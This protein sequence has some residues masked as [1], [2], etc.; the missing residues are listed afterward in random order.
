MRNTGVPLLVVD[1]GGTKCL[2]MF[3]GSDRSVLGEGR[4]DGCNYQTVG[5][6]GARES[7]RQAITQALGQ[8]E[9]ITGDD[10]ETIKVECAVFGMAGLDTE[11]DHEVLTRIIRDV[12]KSE[13]IEANKVIVENDALI[14]LFG[15]AGGQPSVLVISGTGSIVCGVN[16]LG[17]YVRSGGWGHVAGD[18]GSGY[19]I[20]KKA[21]ASVF[22]M[23]DGRG[24]TTL[25]RDGILTFLGLEN[26]EDL[27]N[28]IYGEA[29]SV[30]KVADLSAIVK[31]CVDEG[32]AVAMSIVE[33]S[34]HELFSGVMAVLKEL[35]MA[36]DP[37]QLFLQG[38]VL[39]HVP[40][41]QTKLMGLLDT[42]V[43]GMYQVAADTAL[44]PINGIIS[45]GFDWL[46]KHRQE[47]AKR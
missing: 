44:E 41:I 10:P 40:E 34:A 45:K 9:V 1:G 22:K 20:G 19:W 5:E 13:R 37:F 29:Y 6:T 16:E 21:V 30:D 2:A 15:A 39:S 18:E 33:Q 42:A 28:W 4:S 26:A 36:N 46:N 31:K 43:P 32:D 3:L 24:E 17:R 23:L 7:L 11:R 35:K 8:I 38:G 14:A 47:I 27:Y 12:L 25:L